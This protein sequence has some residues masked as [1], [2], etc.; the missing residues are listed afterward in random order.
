V[1]R[2]HRERGPLTTNSRATETGARERDN[3]LPVARE[4]RYPLDLSVRIPELRRLYHE[5]NA[6][7]WDVARDLDVAAIDTNT[8][9]TDG[10][11]A[12]ATCWS[13]RSWISFADISESE[14]ALVR[15]C[16][17]RDRAADLKYILAARGTERAVATDACH[18]LAN[19]FAHHSH[20]PATLE[21]QSLFATDTIRRA[22]DAR[23][24]FDAFFVAHFVVL[25]A[26]D[27]ALLEAS[28]THTTEPTCRA[29][30]ERIAVDL[31]R[32]EA[33]GLIYLQARTPHLAEDQR[34]LIEANVRAVVRSDVL[35]GVRCSAFL[36]DGV[37]GVDAL[38]E[39][40]ETAAAAGLGTAPLRTQR[41]TVER[42]LAELDATLTNLGLPARLAELANDHLATPGGPT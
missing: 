34:R 41:Q 23:V 25:A 26:I 29:V 8:L 7:I 15:C 18:R 17:E 6:S 40:E 20:Q 5:S 38:I 42:S 27:S 12:A 39:A 3:E 31:A 9:T 35:S 16:I 30:L 28:R 1:A 32:Q 36:P 24:D 11:T 37:P 4:Q 22:L 10:R 33:A 2:Q 21:L 14:A 13:R 19:H